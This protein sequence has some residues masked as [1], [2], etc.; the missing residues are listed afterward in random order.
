MN[1]LAH[2]KHIKDTTTPLVVPAARQ[3]GTANAPRVRTA[4]LEG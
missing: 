1:Q 3:G 4:S 2:L